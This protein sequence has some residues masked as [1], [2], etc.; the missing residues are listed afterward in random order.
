M[1]KAG[2]PRRFPKGEST[3][4]TFLL[5]L[6]LDRAIE[7]LRGSRSAAV[8]LEETLRQ[9]PEIAAQIESQRVSGKV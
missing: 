1:A 7:A 5:S 2:R 4:T 6:E 3:K 8:Y 9:V